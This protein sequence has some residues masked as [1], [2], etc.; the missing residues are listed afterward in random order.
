MSNALLDFSDLPRLT[1]PPEHV[2]PAHGRAAGERQ[3]SA[4][5]RHRARFPA[6][7]TP[8]PRCWMLPP[9]AWAAPGARQPP[10][11][12]G[13]HAR[14][15][16]RLQRRPAPVTEFWTRLGAD[17]RLY[18]K[19]KA[20][21]PAT[22]NAEQRQAHK[23]AM[24]NF[25]LAAPSCTGAAKERFAAHPGAPG[26]AEPEIQRKRARRHRRLCLLRHAEELDGV[27][28]DVQQAALAL[29]S[30]GQGRLQAHAED[31]VLPAGDAVRHSSALREKLYR[32]Y[33][34]RASDQ[35]EG[36]ARKFDNT[37]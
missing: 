31:A 23:N 7:W 28:A 8:L 22:L 14:A 11:Q 27:P 32:A 15:A 6:E 1:D 17:E 9:S 18:A 24:R 35:A 10:Q 13:R 29:P 25:V 3:R 5:N 33:V 37:R 30:R 19:Y 36:D 16:R 2:A 21:D 20:I 26:R 12:R 4:G 34:T